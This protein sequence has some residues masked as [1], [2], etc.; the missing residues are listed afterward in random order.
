MASRSNQAKLIKMKKA[1]RLFPKS[2]AS[3]YVSCGRQPNQEVINGYKERAKSLAFD[4]EFWDRTV[5]RR[6]HGVTPARRLV[7]EQIKRVQEV[8]PAMMCFTILE[9]RYQRARVFFNSDR[10][11]WILMHE[12]FKSR[13]VRTSMTYADKDRCVSAFH[14]DKIRWV[15][16][17][18]TPLVSSE[19]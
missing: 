14:T 3:D 9:N 8:A 17:A 4:E 10:T 7:L 16:F 6:F 2:Y 11:C 5:P 12:N 15:E 18:K 13:E 19:V 1:R